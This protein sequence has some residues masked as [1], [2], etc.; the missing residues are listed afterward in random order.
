MDVLEQRKFEAI[1]FTFKQVS[2]YFQ[3]VFKKLVPAGTATLSIKRDQDDDDDSQEDQ[4][5]RLENATGVS[6]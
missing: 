6:W 4:A 2:K 1:L 5:L 3:E